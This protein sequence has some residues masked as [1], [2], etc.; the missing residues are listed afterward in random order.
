MKNLE[1]QPVHEGVKLIEVEP[2]PPKGGGDFPL[3]TIET[4]RT[5]KVPKTD[6]I[7]EESEVKNIILDTT[8][9][10][11]KLSEV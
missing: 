7:I 9:N 11:D 10:D 3:A 5:Q 8:Q 6:K 4:E 2:Q 1:P